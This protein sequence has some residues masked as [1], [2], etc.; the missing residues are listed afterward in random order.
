MDPRQVLELVARTS[1]SGGAGGSAAESEGDPG[2]TD[3]HL[4]H[5]TKVPA[6]RARTVPLPDD[7]PPVLR[8]RLELAGITELYTHQ[9]R[10]LALAR[11]GRSFVVATGTASGKS[12]CYQLP[13]LETL[14][15]D[16]KATALYL[17]PTKALTRDQ[18]RAL[19][20]LKLP[21]LRAAVVDGDTPREER[22]AI[23]RTAN[24]VLTNPDLLHHSLLPD[25]RHWGDF[26]HRLRW[27]VVD[28]SHA[29]RGV[30]GSHIALILRRLRRLCERYSADPR[31]VLTSA[32]IGNPGEHAATLTGVAVEEVVE[33]GSPRGALDLG[34]WQPPFTDPDEGIRR[35]LLRETGD[36]LASFVGGEVQTLVFTK[37]RKAAE[38]VALFARE[39]LGDSPLADAVRSY[40]AGYLPEE[41]REL[42]QQLRDGR[43]VGV[44]ATEALELGID[45]SGLDAVLLAGYP[46]TAAS[47]WQR[48]GRAGRSG[49]EA[50]GVLVAADDPLDQYLVHHPEE[51]LGRPPEHAIVDPTNPYLLGPHLWCACQEQPLSAEE[52]VAW[53]GDDAPGLLEDGVDRGY[54]RA[55]GERWYWTSRRRAAAMVDI[56]SSGEEDVRIVDVGTGALIG[57]VDG[58]RARSQVHTGAV[59]L[60]Q[61]EQYEIAELDL[62][63]GIATATRAPH[64]HHATRARSDTD[65][66]VLEVLETRPWGEIETGLAKVQVTVTVTGYDV[67]RPGTGEVLDRVPLDLPPTELT[68][69]AV[70]YAVPEHLLD[71]EASLAPA[72]VPGA[73]H[74]AEHAAIGLLPLIALCDRWD[75][76][77][78]STALHP[79]TGRPSVFVYD[80]YA[81]GAGLAERSYR[82]LAEHL[83]ATRTA[84][85]DCGCRSGCPSCVQSPKC[86]NGNE[87]LDK[88]GAV[89]VLDLLLRRA[90]DAP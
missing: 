46:G 29:A 23:K 53:F 13:V 26:L 77:G 88:A 28:E 90:P 56:R 82:R 37:S 70:Y 61:G 12:L 35:S 4:V 34:L 11:E 50:V 67:L 57:D 74:A 3:Q 39:R 5:L 83:G 15:A 68:T 31:F 21:Q 19:R 1:A 55:R 41:R 30:F 16:D 9:A 89:A 43:L 63:R 40:R 36:L 45:V 22:D 24:W 73:L 49:G 44:A 51:L 71:D 80:G 69:V 38:L 14:L 33:D 62:E 20:D 79:D 42:E 87:P 54:L 2:V 52:A 8:G 65:V 76:G 64:I 75:I 10:S 59:Y 48:L 86:G 27:V 66:R 32:T 72:R 84:I 47:F 25:H 7:L 17:G 58:S 18:L 85:A 78:L 60:H 6:R 81:G